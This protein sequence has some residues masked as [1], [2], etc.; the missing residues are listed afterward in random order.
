ML[1]IDSCSGRY[2]GAR[3]FSLLVSVQ[4]VVPVSLRVVPV[5]LRVVSSPLHA[6]DRWF[7]VFAVERHMVAINMPPLVNHVAPSSSRKGSTNAPG[8]QVYTD[9]R[10]TLVEEFHMKVWTL[11]Q[12]RTA[13]SSHIGP[14]NNRGT[15][16][17]TFNDEENKTMASKRKKP[18]KSYD[19]NVSGHC[20][21]IYPE[22]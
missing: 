6:S 18:N 7:T 3:L 5:S 12:P 17:F 15:Q 10:R 4:C 8:W 9:V 22:N 2:P 13:V 16:G 1:L 14:L 19:V 20:L 11:Q 21:Q